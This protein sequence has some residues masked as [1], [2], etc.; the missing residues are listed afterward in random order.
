MT[1]KLCRPEHWNSAL[2]TLLV[3]SRN[4]NSTL[5]SNNQTNH[6]RRNIRW[7]LIPELLPWNPFWR[8]HDHFSVQ[9]LSA[10]RERNSALQNGNVACVMSTDY[11]S[12]GGPAPKKGKQMLLDYAPRSRARAPRV[13]MPANCSNLLKHTA[14]LRM[15]HACST[16]KYFIHAQASIG[17]I[18]GHSLRK[19]SLV[20]KQFFISY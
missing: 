15:R 7:F 8:P 3:F 14:A 4:L 12:S 16:N 10:K 20:V 6:L 9:K 2:P 5:T 11:P 17:A 1:D 13:M 19:S 18:V